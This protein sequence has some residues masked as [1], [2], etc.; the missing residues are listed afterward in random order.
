MPREVRYSEDGMRRRSSD[1]TYRTYVD[2]FKCAKCGQ[3]YNV[4]DSIVSEEDGKLYCEVC[5]EKTNEVTDD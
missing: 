3:W 5:Y 4:D 1:M 2:E